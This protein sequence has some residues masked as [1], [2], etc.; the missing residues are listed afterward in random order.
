LASIFWSFKVYSRAG[1]E[2]ICFLLPAGFTLHAVEYPAADINAET[3]QRRGKGDLTY[4]GI[5]VVMIKHEYYERNS[6]DKKTG[7]HYK[8]TVGFDPLPD[9]C[10]YHHFPECGNKII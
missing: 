3:R 7:H 4:Q 5:I 6:R 9:F 8:K 1:S 2:Q 10:H